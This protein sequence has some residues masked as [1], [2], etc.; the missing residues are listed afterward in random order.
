MQYVSVMNVTDAYQL[1]RLSLAN[2]FVKTAISFLTVLS[3]W[4]SRKFCFFS[5]FA[6]RQ[7]FKIVLN[8]KILWN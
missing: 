8:S 3:V 2:F 6:Q 1:E 5:N 4:L 7:A